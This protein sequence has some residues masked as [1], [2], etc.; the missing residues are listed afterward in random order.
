MKYT[1]EELLKELLDMCF[2]TPFGSNR[3]E[4]SYEEG[5]DLRKVHPVLVEKLA[6]FMEEH[7]DD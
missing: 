7:K 1:S 5:T 3:L 6:L 4:Y 2:F